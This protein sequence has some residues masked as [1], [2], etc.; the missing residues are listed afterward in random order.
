MVFIAH[1]MT[2]FS[3]NDVVVFSNCD[4]VRL[5]AY[6]GEMTATLPVVHQPDGIP[7]APVVFKD[8]WDFW[9]ARSY[10]Y[11]KRS[12]QKVTLLAE[13]IIGGQVVCTEKKMPARRSTRLRLY[14]DDMGRPLVAD[15]S[16]FIVVVAE[17]TDDNGNVRRSAIEHISFTVEGEGSIIGDASIMANPR[18][19]EWG[20]API[21]VRS[22][23]K[24]GK[25]R[26][27]ARPA[28]E[29]GRHARDRERALRR[30]DV[31]RCQEPDSLAYEQPSRRM[32]QRRRQVCP[33]G[34]PQRGGKA[35]RPRGG[36]APAARLRNTIALA[37]DGLIGLMGS[38]GLMGPLSPLNPLNPLSPLSP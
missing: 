12:W 22:T 17:V 36:G 14:A 35:P 19:V 23:H 26:I 15:G 31:L 18:K 38:M 28:F 9:K 24:A 1:E 6:D 32:A 2:P 30:T 5:T 11:T 16:D 7:S 34:C 21:L 33:Q 37:L 25:I 29:G 20:S 10:S 8:F 13:G 27:I 3:G 4:S